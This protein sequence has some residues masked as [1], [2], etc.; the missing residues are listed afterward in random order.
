MD[1]YEFIIENWK[2]EPL[3]SVRMVL[4]QGCK[5]NVIIIKYLRKKKS[6]IM[7][8]QEQTMGVIVHINPLMLGVA[9]LMK[10]EGDVVI[11]VI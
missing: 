9:L 1:Y 3:L 8:G 6:Y 4:N 11:L 10:P 5:E 2:E 7:I